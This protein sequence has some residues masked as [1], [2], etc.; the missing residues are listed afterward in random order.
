MRSAGRLASSFSLLFLYAFLNPDFTESGKNLLLSAQIIPSMSLLTGI[1]LVFLGGWLKRNNNSR[2]LYLIFFV[3]GGLFMILAIAQSVGGISGYD[4]PLNQTFAAVG[5]A[6]LSI[7]A[8]LVWKLGTH[9]ERR[10]LV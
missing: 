1:T 4:F 6:V 10:A 5:C 3:A 8:F 9:G 7:E 2:K